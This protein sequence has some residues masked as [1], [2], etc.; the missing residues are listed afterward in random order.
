MATPDL[1]ERQTE[2]KRLLDEGKTPREIGEALK[3]TENA[4]YQHI[5]RMRGNG[6]RVN[7]ARSSGSKSG[8]RKRSGSRSSRPAPAPAPSEPRL[9]TPLQAIRARKDAIAHEIRDA[10]QAL[11]SAERAAK[12]AGEA[13][14]KT[15]AK[16]K[17]ELSALD[18]AEAAITGKPVIKAAKSRSRSTAAKASSNGKTGAGAKADASEPATVA[19][20]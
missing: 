14:E 6:H 20:T 9:M 16:T 5:R 12:L 17:D 8:S 18:K 15:Q 19:T 2:I 1:T 4:V 7:T 11:E 13:H 3:I 10:R